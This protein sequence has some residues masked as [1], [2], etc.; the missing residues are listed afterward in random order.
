MPSLAKLESTH[1]TYWLYLEANIPCA[2]SFSSLQNRRKRK[3]ANILLHCYLWQSLHLF[4]VWLSFFFACDAV[5]NFVKGEIPP[6]MT[7][8]CFLFCSTYVRDW[9]AWCAWNLE[10]TIH[11]RVKCV[12]MFLFMSCSVFAL[13]VLSR[14]IVY[15]SKWARQGKIYFPASFLAST[16][17]PINSSLGM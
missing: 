13:I 6:F 16:S 11:G 15:N 14:D 12:V 9:L 4:M 1:Y 3:E 7:S 2:D 17:M 8:F 5:N 10:R